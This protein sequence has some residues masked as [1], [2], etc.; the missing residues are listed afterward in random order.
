MVS[1]VPLRSEVKIL[2]FVLNSYHCVKCEICVVYFC[3]FCFQVKR[4]YILELITG[5]VKYKIDCKIHAHFNN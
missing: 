3:G 4:F 5:I 1:C 2:E